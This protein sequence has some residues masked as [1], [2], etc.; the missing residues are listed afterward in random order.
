MMSF[1]GN[2][3]P[4]NVSPERLSLSQ[5]AVPWARPSWSLCYVAGTSL[6]AGDKVEGKLLN[7]RA[8]GSVGELGVKQIARR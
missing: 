5:A 4:G 7:S 3:I 1:P 8:C 6:G 2:H